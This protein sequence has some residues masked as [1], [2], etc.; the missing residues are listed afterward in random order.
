ML[1]GNGSIEVRQEHMV[2]T[3][4][5]SRMEGNI[6]HIHIVQLRRRE[7]KEARRRSIF[8]FYS[9]FLLSFINL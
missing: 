4:W 9:F 1:I 8:L 2:V 7:V 6:E 5:Y 3:G